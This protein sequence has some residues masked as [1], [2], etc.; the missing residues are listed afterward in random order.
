M[1]TNIA[2][3]FEASLD[4]PRADPPSLPFG[5]DSYGCE[6]QRTNLSTVCFDGH[7]AEED[8]SDNGAVLDCNEGND[9][10]TV[11]TELID[12]VSLSSGGKCR[13][14]QVADSHGVSFGSIAD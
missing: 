3:A 14:Q 12:E 7:S 13:L 2:S 4:Q 10:L 1:R 8:L 9:G 6:A 11:T 5:S